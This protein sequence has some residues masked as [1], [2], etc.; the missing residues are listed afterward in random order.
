MKEVNRVRIKGDRVT[1]TVVDRDSWGTIRSR[2]QMTFR[3]RAFERA[4]RDAEV[5]VP[6]TEVPR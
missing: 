1:L 3:R 4:L 5:T 6:W 2:R